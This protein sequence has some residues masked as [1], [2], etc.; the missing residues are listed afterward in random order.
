M[1]EVGF[2]LGVEILLAVLPV[3]ERMQS[4]AVVAVL[5]KDQQGDYVH[6]ADLQR[7]RR[8][9]DFVFAERIRC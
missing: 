3:N 8:H 2:E 4:V 7:T 9:Q 6:L 1:A 5:V